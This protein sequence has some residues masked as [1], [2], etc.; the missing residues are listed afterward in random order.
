MVLTK[1][2]I[3]ASSKEFSSEAVAD[4]AIAPTQLAKIEVMKAEDVLV[5]D[6][7]MTFTLKDFGLKFQL[8]SG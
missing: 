7:H 5:N 6:A 4:S 2:G 3:P 8:H 1:N